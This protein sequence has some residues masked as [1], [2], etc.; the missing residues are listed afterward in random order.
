[1]SYASVEWTVDDIRDVRPKMT[2][3]QA[4]AFLSSNENNIRDRM[5]ERGWDAIDTL[6]DM[7]GFTLREYG[8]NE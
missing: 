1:M 8:D 4:E 2:V 3:E 7:D 5:V 6:L